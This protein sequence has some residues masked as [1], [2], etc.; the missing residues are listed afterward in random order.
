MGESLVLRFLMSA[1][2]VVTK[3]EPTVTATSFFEELTLMGHL[4]ISLADHRLMFLF[5]GYRPTSS[6]SSDFGDYSLSLSLFL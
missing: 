3:L 2:M 5:A 4:S 1:E 6:S